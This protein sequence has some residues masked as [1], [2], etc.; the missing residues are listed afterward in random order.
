ML[1]KH[2]FVLFAACLITI[3]AATIRPPLDLKLIDNAKQ[4][5]SGCLDGTPGGYYYSVGVGKQ[6]NNCLLYF[7]DGGWCYDDLD[8]LA[9]SNTSLG[10]SKG[11]WGQWSPTFD[12]GG[13]FSSNCGVNPSFC[14]WTRVTLQY[15]DGNSFSGNRLTPYNV[16]GKKIFFRGH[17]ILK[18]TLDEL[19]A[20]KLLGEANEVVLT[21]A[22]AG[23]LATFLHADSVQ[24]Y[25][26]LAAP[27]LTK[28]GAIPLSGFFLDHANIENQH[29]YAQQIATVFKMSNASAGLNQN[30]IANTADPYKW[31]CNFA[32][33][34][35]QYTKSRIFVINSAVDSWQ[36]QCILGAAKIPWKSSENGACGKIKG[37]KLC[38]TQLNCT[39]QQMQNIVG[40]ENDFFSDIGAIPTF[41]GNGN[42][43]FLS[44]C[45][46]HCEALY[47]GFY[48]NYTIGTTKLAS[49]V[50]HWWSDNPATP[51]VANQYLDCILDPLKIPRF[52]NPMCGVVGKGKYPF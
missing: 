11:E 31:Q 32:H 38:V 25:L 7:R 35:Y 2:T 3:N 52:C 49:A 34:S 28:Y 17:S 46:T 50:A 42:G 16:K 14:N 43:A 45:F 30:C 23:G 13:I 41:H 4:I 44:S 9:R 51:S 5:G 33:Y 6:A 27:K 1:K 21:G 20:N 47:D 40:F 39:D 19:V 15:C 10:S 29:I 18:S 12:M 24:D 37:W 26:H 36:T 22:S 8:C 48:A